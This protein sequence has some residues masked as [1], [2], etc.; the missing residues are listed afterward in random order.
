MESAASLDSQVFKAPRVC[1]AGQ[2]TLVHRVSLDQSAIQGHQ[3]VL[4]VEGL[5]DYQV[6]MEHLDGLVVLDL[7]ASLV[8]GVLW[9][10][11]DNKVLME[12]LDLQVPLDSQ[13]SPAQ[14][15]ILACKDLWDSPEHLDLKEQLVHLDSLAVRVIEV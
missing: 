6:R 4:G 10:S 8:T 1:L 5:T 13:D 15:V 12:A 2:V 9:D 7:L 11:L 14:W 3:E